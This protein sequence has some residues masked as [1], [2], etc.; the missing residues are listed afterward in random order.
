MQKA[1]KI[2]KIDLLSLLAIPLLLL[3]TFFK[4]VAKAFEKTTIFLGLALVALVILL[5]LTTATVPKDIG[6]LII[7]FI[8]IS[9]CIGLIMLFVGWGFALIS[10]LAIAAWSFLISLFDSL[11]ELSYNGYLSLYT[12]CEADYKILSLNGKKVPNAI[13]CIF[14]TIL[15]GLSW[16]ITTIVSL[17]YVIATVFSVGLVLIT[18]FDLNKNIKDA[19]GLGIFQYM[20]MSP[21]HSVLFGIL[22]YII[23]I[24][25][26][27]VGIMALA[28]E[29]YEWGQELKMTGQEISNEITDLIKS[30]LKMASGSSEEVAQNLT[31]MQKLEEHLGSLEALGQEVTDV[32][33]QKDSPLLRSYWGVYMRNLNPLVEEC[34]AKKSMD[35]GRFKQLIPQ[36]QLL[37]KQRDD[38]QKL[39]DK[40]KA[41]LLNPTGASV[42][43]A[44]CNTL[45]KLEKRYKALCK[46][47]HPDMAEGDTETFQKMQA[48]YK[49]LK[50]SM[51][52]Q[53]NTQTK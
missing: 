11:Y 19:F 15:K 7:G 51:T 37:D 8:L 27:I 6:Q 22:I 29:W 21:L 17:S 36:I 13:A 9:V 3:A 47:Y 18:L 16:L 39:A 14:Y 35:V 38:V 48:E 28:S 26:I 30:E 4:L 24:G 46:T 20:S 5:L 10:G 44:G 2:I 23:M 50:A 42:F 45:E 34:S 1:L 52:P 33:E 49:V 41:E 43:F 40:L 12:S 25:V 32:L 53:G 31:Y